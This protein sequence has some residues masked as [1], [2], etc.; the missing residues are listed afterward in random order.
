MSNTKTSDLKK[1][2]KIRSDEIIICDVRNKL[3]EESDK[4]R[5]LLDENK[6]LE[7]KLRKIEEKNKQLY[8]DNV[9][10]KDMY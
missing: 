6:L 2:Q 7:T 4:V 3:Q 8:Q 1:A 9:Q 5:T 10:L